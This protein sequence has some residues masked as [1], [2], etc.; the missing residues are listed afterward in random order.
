M[1]HPPL[2]PQANYTIVGKYIG[3]NGGKLHAKRRETGI[4]ML[5]LLKVIF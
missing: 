4:A 1:A 5:C 3:K 2:L